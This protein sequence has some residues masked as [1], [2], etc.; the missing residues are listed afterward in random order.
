ME[1]SS[2]LKQL[3]PQ[4]FEQFALETYERQYHNIAVYRDYIQLLGFP[5]PKTI[6]EIPFLPISF[7]KTHQVLPSGVLA[8]KVFLSSGTSLQQR[9]Q[10]HIQDLRWYETALTIAFE[11]VFGAAQ[12]YAFIALL[13]SYL[14]NGD[15]SLIYMVDC[16]IAESHHEI[17]GYYLAN[18]A[19]VAATYEKALEA[20]KIPFIFGV[21]YAL[22][23]LA[24]KGLNLSKAIILETGGMKGK[25]QELTKKELHTQ[26]KQG[27]QVANIY[28]EYGMTEL[29]SQAY[30][31]TDAHIF[32]PPP[33]CRV[34]IRDAYDPFTYVQEG[35]KGGINF[36][37]LAN[38][39]SCSFIQ[40]DD[41]GRLSHAGFTV[42]GRLEASDIRGCNLL[43]D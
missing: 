31:L 41:L 21:S 9:S 15:S 6:Q 38:Q 13:P 32:E 10:H 30:C 17:S 42:E 16:L 39:W 23:D 40:T 18:L 34:F 27:F 12:Q 33:W 35:Q 24:E 8:Q 5:H 14:E 28:S 3:N 37:D 36:I 19:E 4:N 20:G 2:F 43:V 11:R 29:L 22:L 7:F 1:P 25:R 26:L